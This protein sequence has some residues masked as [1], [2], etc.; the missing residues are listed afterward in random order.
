M[1]EVQQTPRQLESEDQ[2]RLK[3]ILGLKPGIYLAV[4]Y[5]AVLLVILFFMLIYPGIV[6]S[7]SVIILKTEPV[8]AALRVD[9]VYRGTAPENVFISK[10]VHVLEL[11]L[12]GF[13][14]ERIECEIPGRLFASV[15]F[16]RRYPLEV[17]LT[18]ADPEA[19]FITAARDYADWT[20]GGEPTAVWQVPLSLSEGA[21]RAGGRQPE[22]LLKASARFAVT[23]AALRDLIRAKTIT[24]N[25]GL[26][27]SPLSLTRSATD[28]MSFLSENPGGAVW[29][30]ETL[31]PESA[32]LV[33][34]SSWYQKQLA[35]SAAIGVQ[36]SLAPPPGSEPA[37]SLVPPARRLSVGGLSFT[38]MAGGTLVQGEPFPF[39]V[40]IR[41]F[42]ISENEVPAS[43]FTDFLEANPQWRP[44][45]REALASEEL[46]TGNY[47]VD[48]GSAVGRTDDIS[49]TSISWYAAQAFCGWLGEQ[50]PSSMNA[51]ELRL[52]TEAEWEYAAK[53][54]R[55]WKASGDA[56]EIRNME[57][58]AW[59]WCYDPYA[60][61]AFIDAPG[62]V[63][64]IGSP[65]RAV[66]G[67]S[68]LNSAGSITPETRASLPPAFCSPFVSFRVV[69][70]EKGPIIRQ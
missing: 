2:V 35:L 28:I 60:P 4:I 50:L 65:E 59:E 29:L 69:I 47:L 66:R 6:R 42:M 19:V 46:V 12:P 36:E 3:P 54:V 24:D 68:R 31:P 39:T 20:F 48:D 40:P 70:A 23:G 49:V 27:P 58:G 51:Y 13:I 37:A 34:S 1:H 10:G 45:Q 17:T 7:G 11:I 57:D 38:G 67:G 64:A 18:T 9:G 16:P 33:T 43:V 62:A 52:P 44:D 55:R 25:G 61:L 21:Y 53:S 22:E 8:G 30:A 56:A 32:A 41:G 26:P 5:A 63:T 15:L 14:T